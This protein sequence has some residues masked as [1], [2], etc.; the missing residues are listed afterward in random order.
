[1]MLVSNFTKKPGMRVTFGKKLFYANAMKGI[2]DSK[3]GILCKTAVLK[4][5]LLSS[6][7]FLRKNNDFLPAKENRSIQRNNPRK[8]YISK[9][10]RSH[11]EPAYHDHRYYN[12]LT[13]PLLSTKTGQRLKIVQSKDK[14]SHHEP[15]CSAKSIN[16]VNDCVIIWPPNQDIVL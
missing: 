1:M 14:G 4:T 10:K 11:H 9:N 8:H 7:A 6:R 16:Q 5:L 3:I 2:I 12:L 13:L 15:A